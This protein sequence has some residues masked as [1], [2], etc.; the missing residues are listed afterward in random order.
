MI[1]KEVL[2]DGLKSAGGIFESHTTAIRLIALL[3]D[4][5]IDRIELLEARVKLLDER[6]TKLEKC[7]G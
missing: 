4:K 3:L 6:L 7:R 2:K 5:N 1:D